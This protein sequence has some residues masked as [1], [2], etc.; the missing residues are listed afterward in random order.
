V[1][2]HHFTFDCAGARL[3][4]SLDQAPGSTGLLLVTGGNEVRAGARS[5]QAALA[6]QVAAAGFPVLRFDRRGC[7]DSE[8]VNAGYRASGPDIAAALHAFRARCPHV[9]LV[10]GMGNCDAA[11]ALMLAGGAGCDALLLSN[12]WI[13]EGDTGDRLRGHYT[14]RMK[15]AAALKRLLSGRVALRPLLQSLFTAARGTRPPAGPTSEL[16]RGLDRFAGPVRFLVAE[17]DRTAQAFLSAW[18]PSDRRI[19]RCPG[20]SHAYV[21]PEARAWLLDQVLEALREANGAN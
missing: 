12:P 9:T 18:D 7:G 14:A 13:F 5:G 10:V 3:V 4:A 15:D 16:A 21:E 20:A 6:A 19:M 8:G 1:T 2:R 11:S 17:R